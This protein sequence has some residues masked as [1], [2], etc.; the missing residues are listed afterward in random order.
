MITYMGMTGPMAGLALIEWIKHP[1]AGNRGEVEVSKITGRDIIKMCFLAVVTT[2][3]FY[4]ILDYFNTSNMLFSTISVTT[5]FIGVYLTY[6]RSEYYALGYAANDVVLIILWTYAT[7]E[8]RAYVAVL[9]CFV[10][11]FVNDIYGFVAWRRMKDR[12]GI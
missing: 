7:L 4:F 2:V 1:Y 10:T 11:F 8:N 9:M 5:S 3:V 6:K 12:Q